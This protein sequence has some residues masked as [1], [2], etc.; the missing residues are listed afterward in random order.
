MLVGSMLKYSLLGDPTEF[1]LSDP[2]LTLLASCSATTFDFA[3]W[4]SIDKSYDGYDSISILSSLMQTAISEDR[5]SLHETIP[6]L[7]K[8]ILKLFEGIIPSAIGSIKNYVGSF[9]FYDMPFEEFRYRFSLAAQ[10]M[11]HARDLPKSRLEVMSK[12][13]RGIAQASEEYQ[14]D[15]SDYG[16]LSG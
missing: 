11:S 5:L 8:P 14:E 9:S 6:Y 12:L 3:S 2:R 13:C 15:M 7:Y 4:G 10:E 1:K 16:R